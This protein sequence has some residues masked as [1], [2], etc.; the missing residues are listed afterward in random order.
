M[1]MSDMKAGVHYVVTKGTKD[2]AFK[3]GDN[4]E[5][6]GLTKD[7][8]NKQAGGWMDSSDLKE[9]GYL[10]VV[11]VDIDINYLEK[12]IKRKKEQLE[13]EIVLLNSLLGK[14]EVKP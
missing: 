12:K 11:E 8:L 9:S 4:V 7:I 1:K 13:K 5:L 14:E 10:D 2:K 6:C 3:K